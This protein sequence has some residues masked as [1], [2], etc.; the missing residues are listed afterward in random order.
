ML[1]WWL[2]GA[3][4]LVGI[5][6]IY[7]YNHAIFIR[8]NFKHAWHNIDV[9][10]VQRLDE[11]TTLVETTK[12]MMAF[13]QEFLTRIGELRSQYLGAQ[14]SA[15]RVRLENEIRPAMEKIVAAVEAYPKLA[16]HET[17]LRLMQ[18]LSALESMIADRREF[19]NDSVKLY[20]TYIQIFPDLI[21]ARVF[22]FKEQPFLAIPP[23]PV[24]MQLLTRAD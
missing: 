5:W 6:A 1:S 18:R 7:T 21:L 10:L 20:N 22:G 17:V 13:E 15:Q 16:S 4:A 12:G 2:G 24:S 3:A 23:Q 9:L 19:Y 8:N 11:I 14:T